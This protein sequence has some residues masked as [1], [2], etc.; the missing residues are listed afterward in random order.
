MRDFFYCLIFPHPLNNHRA[1]FLHHRTILFLISFFIITSLFFSS[2]ANPFAEKLK[3]F[4]DISVQELVTLT[5]QKRAENGFGTLSENSQLSIAAGKKADDMFAKNYW[6]HNSPDGIT[7]WVFIKQ[8]GY[9]YVYAGENL[10][11]GFNS[12]S[13]VVNAWMAS[14]THRANILSA[15]YKD[16][17]FAV[18]SGSL[19]GEQTFLVVQEFGSRQVLSAARKNTVQKQ[20]TA[21]AKKVL[22]FEIS[23]YLPFKPNLSKSA[24]IAII[25]ILGFMAVLLTDLVLTERRKIARFVGHNLDHAI[26]LTV[27]VLVI[28]IFNTGVVL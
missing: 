6:A 11:R 10:A 14:S 21:T 5:N 22:G 9:N 8:A 18:K 3:A 7:P 1:R 26:F 15:N 4:A 20:K 24:E 12:S 2:A 19:N 27:I 23:S 28:Y 13:D 17:G 16:V 25:L